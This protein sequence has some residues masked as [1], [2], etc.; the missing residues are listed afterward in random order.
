MITPH[1]LSTE[2]KRLLQTTPPDQFLNI[3][4]GGGFFEKTKGLDRIYDI[5][6]LIHKIEGQNGVG[7]WLQVVIDKHRF[8]SV[9]DSSLKSFYLAFP[10]CKMPIPSNIYTDN[11]KVHRKIPRGTVSKDDHYFS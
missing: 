5:G 8:P 3:I 2:A 4:K 11:Y 6:M 9:V 1:Q 10:S 7:D